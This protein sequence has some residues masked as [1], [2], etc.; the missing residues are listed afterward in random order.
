MMGPRTRRFVLAVHITVSIGW[1]GAV[2]AYLALDLTVASSDD[3]ATLR[4]AYLAMH[5]ITSWVIVPLAL[6]SLATGLVMALGTRWGLLRHYWVVISLVLTILA[7]VVLLVETRTIAS[8]AAVAADLAASDAD[9]RAL[10]STL[11]HS[12]GGLVVLLVIQV[13]NIYK[14]QGMT[15]YGR[16]KQRKRT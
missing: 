9:I 6:A 5:T 12:V 14:P 8:L 16:R 7:T 13:L 3:V 11:V 10:P 2:A 1:I 4:S 15:R